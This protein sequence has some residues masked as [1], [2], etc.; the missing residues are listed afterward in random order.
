MLFSSVGM[1][2]TGIQLANLRLAPVQMMLTG[3]PDSSFSEQ[4][5]WWFYEYY[6]RISITMKL[7]KQ[8][9]WK[10]RTLLG[11]RRLQDQVKTFR[12]FRRWHGSERSEPRPAPQYQQTWGWGYH[13]SKVKSWSLP[14]C[15]P[16]G[17]WHPRLQVARRGRHRPRSSLKENL[18]VES[19]PEERLMVAT[20]NI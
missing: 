13:V 18:G 8:F 9:T 5:L 16:L 11:S 7:N 1:D 3:H 20:K 14:A 6:L 19:V 4:I 15:G 2:S 10:V 17:C 12:L